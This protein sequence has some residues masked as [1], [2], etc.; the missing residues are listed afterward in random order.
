[1]KRSF[2]MTICA[3]LLLSASAQAQLPT[4]FENLKVLPKDIGQRELIGVMRGFSMGLGVR[5]Q[6]CH[7]GEEG[8]PLSE[9]D[10][11]SDKKM[12]KRTAREMLKMVE[13]IN[14][15]HIGKIAGLENGALQV[16]CVTCHHGQARPVL[17][18]EV[19]ADEHAKNG[20]EGAIKKYGELKKEFYGGFTYDF[21]ELTLLNFA[22]ELLV[23]EKYDDAVAILKLNIE[24]FPESAMSFYGIGEAFE[25]LGNNAAAIENFEKS[26][27]ISPNNPR[28]KMKIP[29]LKK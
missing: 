15:E 9:F 11:V 23:K 24:S 6:H 25:K 7:I 3:A 5:C 14:A 29:Q 10:F 27:E 2:L 18:E 12:T 17:L 20:V 22:R 21:T 1:M 13:T 28:A 26:L 4:K 16:K 8:Q 19:L